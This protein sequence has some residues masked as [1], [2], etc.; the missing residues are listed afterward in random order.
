LSSAAV[1]AWHE[2]PG[3]FERLSPPWLSV[4]VLERVGGIKGGLLKFA[5]AKGPVRIQWSLQ[6]DP[7]QYIQGVQ[8]RDHQ[9]LGPFKTWSHLHR[10]ESD[11]HDACY[12]ID[13]I[14]YELPAHFPLRWVV[15][16]YFAGEL[17]R[18]FLFRH[19]LLVDDLT[20]T[21]YPGGGKMKILITGSTGLVGTALV[22]LLTS[23]GHV[24]TRL[25]RP[26]TKVN[27]KDAN[28]SA[29]IVWDPDKETRALDLAQLE[30]FDAVVHLAGENLAGKRWDEARKAQLRESRIQGTKLLSEAL[31]KLTS[32]PKVFICASAI[33]FYGNRAEETLT[34]KSTKGKGFLADLCH[35]WEAATQ[36]AA[37]AGIRVVN[38]RLGVVLDARSGAL[39]KMLLPFELG[40]G[41]QIG[42]GDQY[43][44]WITL[45]DA[46]AA[47]LHAIN[48]PELVGPVN[49]TAPQ[50]VTNKEFTKTLGKVL[51]RPTLIPIPT[52]GLRLLFGEMADECLIAGQKVLPDKLQG[53]N[54]K[55]RNPEIEP[56]LRSVLGK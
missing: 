6:H 36:Q 10:V 45:N 28:S 29:T 40:A 35:D 20:L 16:E 30:G 32:K 24:V 55:F 31:A 46:V 11:G 37:A 56:A 4:E 14:E 8:F 38:L 22:P 1:F 9:A 52:F 47:I 12:L 34:E 53:S 27:G 42:S 17:E 3:A 33:G 23:Q 41:G 5:I 15:Q 7:D 18:L 25:I 2:Q 26:Q 54:F 44:S 51:F 49:V 50:P 43:F 21:N 48:T 19:R 13:D 39:A